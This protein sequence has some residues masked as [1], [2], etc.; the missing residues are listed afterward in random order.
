[1]GGTGSGVRV[2]RACYV[3]VVVFHDGLWRRD[4]GYEAW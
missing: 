4:G 3:E 2:G 1:L